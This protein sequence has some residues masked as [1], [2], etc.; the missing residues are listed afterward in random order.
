[1]RYATSSTAS[2][3]FIGTKQPLRGRLEVSETILSTIIG[4]WN[5]DPQSIFM[6]PV[7]LPSGHKHARDGR[8]PILYKNCQDNLVPY[9]SVRRFIREK[10]SGLFQSLGPVAFPIILPVLSIKKV[11]GTPFTS[12]RSRVSPCGSSKTGKA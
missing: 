12:K 9:F 10:T 2:N 3:N 4:Q 11:V 6:I 8:S 1:M 5:E 7:G